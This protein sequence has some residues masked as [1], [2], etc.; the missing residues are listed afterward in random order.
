MMQLTRINLQ[1][2]QTAYTTQYQK[3]K[4]PNQKVNQ[5]DT[6]E[7]KS[8]PNRHFFKE[9]IQVANRLMKKM[10]NITNYQRN[11]NQT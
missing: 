8:E 9:S 4:E 2:I 3:Y 5:I 7:P 1:N 6:C 10:F 11:A